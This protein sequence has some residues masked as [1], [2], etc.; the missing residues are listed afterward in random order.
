[1]VRSG[2]YPHRRFLA[3]LGREDHAAVDRALVELDVES[4]RARTLETLSGGERRRSWLAMV[5][6]QQAPILLL[7]EPTAAL[8][9][10]HQWEVIALLARINREHGCTLVVVLHDLAQAARLAHRVAL[11]HRGRLY[12][13]GTPESVLRLEALRDVFGV[14][15][16]IDKLDGDPI[17]QVRGAALPVRSL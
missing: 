13:V 7:D 10:R 1:V 16:R 14:D 17:Y 6:A 3:S 5:L 15:V 12:E 2:R 4:L 9:L 11:L 8:D